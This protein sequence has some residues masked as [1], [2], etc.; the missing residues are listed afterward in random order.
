MDVFD[1]STYRHSE[2]YARA[3]LHRDGSTTTRAAYAG[4]E[5]ILGG[6]MMRLMKPRIVR[7]AASR[8]L[9]PSLVAALL[10]AL[11]ACVP[12][13]PTMAADAGARLS[14]TAAAVQTALDERL[15]GKAIEFQLGSAELTEDGRRSLAEVARILAFAGDVTVEIRGY[16][17][18]SGDARSNFLLSHDR[19]ETVRAYLEAR[20]VAATL[21]RKGYGGTRPVG[22][23]TTAAGRARNRRIEFVVIAP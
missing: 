4:L 16:A 21:V 6:A 10:A 5:K 8:L 7:Q 3:G 18:G 2:C 9:T 20:N 1:N 14:A 23:N 22:D 17:D 12:V 15:S 13:S 19:A 11:L